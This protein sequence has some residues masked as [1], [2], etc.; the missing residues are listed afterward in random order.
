MRKLRKVS[1]FLQECLDNIDPEIK[2]MSD[3]HMDMWNCFHTAKQGDVFIR[4]DGVEM[5]FNGKEAKDD[6]FWEV[7]TDPQNNRV[8]YHRTGIPYLTLDDNDP[9]TLISKKK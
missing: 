6:E 7:L 8:L 2:E 1:P 5:V 3:R 4:R 9:M